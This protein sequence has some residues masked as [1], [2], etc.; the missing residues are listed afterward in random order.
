MFSKPK[1][2]QAELQAAT[3]RLETLNRLAEKSHTNYRLI[4]DERYKQ[5]YDGYM[6]QELIALKAFQKM[7]EAMQK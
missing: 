1:Y 5:L 6:Q 7:Q 4:H 3:A 2:S